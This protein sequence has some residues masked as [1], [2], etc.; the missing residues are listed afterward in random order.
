[1]AT[2]LFTENQ[3]TEAGGSVGGL[4]SYGANNVN[5]TTAEKFLKPGGFSGAATGQE[6]FVPYPNLL[7]TLKNL[8]ITHGIPGLGGDV[9]YTVMK[10]SIAT[11]LT[12]TMDASDAVG[13]SSS[14]TVTAAAGD[15]VSIR[16]TKPF[17]IT[18]SPANIAATLGIT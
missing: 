10:N 3:L 8:S 15:S 13:S 16:V 11:D 17:D 4:L 1:M 18:T 14:G 6:V 9:I 5:T 12:V 2:T 7:G